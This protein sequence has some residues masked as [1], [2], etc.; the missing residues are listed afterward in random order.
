MSLTIGVNLWTVYGWTLPEPVSASVIRRIGEMGAS[1][2]ELV[3]DQSHNRAEDLLARQEELLGVVADAGLTVPSIASAL[4]HRINLGGQ[5]PEMRARALDLA[6]SG[7]RVAAAY[8]ARVL[9]VVAGFGEP[10][11][12]YARTYANAVGSLR[13][14]GADA[15]EHGVV[16][17]V[18]NV[19]S[20]F[21]GS[22]GEFARFLADVDHPAVQAYI[23]PG[24]GAAVGHG[25]PEIWVTALRDR[26][27]M[28]HAKDYDRALRAHV[29][30]GQGELD[31]GRI[32]ATL[33][34]VGY[35]GHVVV[36]TPP[37][38]GRAGV[39]TDAGLAAAETSVRW[40]KQCLEGTWSGT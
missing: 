11:V 22:P 37:L 34:D 16:I 14:A 10:G 6:R 20:N 7:V 5:D 39:K 8:G 30:C 4:F 23:D 35:D 32:L 17:G 18:E 28:V 40:L 24:N 13:R 19:S 2:V 1:G 12:E 9:L 38:S 27:A 15:A 29:L 25:Y 21:L 36:E 31:W 3:L 33:R 26:I